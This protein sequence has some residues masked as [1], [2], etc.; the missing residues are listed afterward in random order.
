MQ[1]NIGRRGV[2]KLRYGMIHSTFGDSEGVSIVMKQIGEALHEFGR[3]PVKNISYLVGDSG[4]RSKRVFVE[5]SFSFKS[6]LIAMVKKKYSSGFTNKDVSDLE[7]AIAFG[8][9]R[10]RAYV[11]KNKIDV[12][13]SHNSAY[14][15][16]FVMAL[17]LSRYFSEEKARGKKAPYH[18]VWWHDSHLEREVFLKPSKIMKNYLIEGICGPNVDYIFFINGGQY[19]TALK[20]FRE[21]DRK[22]SGFL[23]KVEKNHLIVYNTSELFI[24]RFSDLEKGGVGKRC[25]EFICDFNVVGSLKSRG[26]NFSET[27]FCLQGTRMV[28]RK[29][30]DFAL[31]YLYKLLQESRSR[32]MYDSIYFLIS[33]HDVDGCRKKLEKLNRELAKKYK[34]DKFVLV[35]AEDYYNKTKL[36]FSDYPQIFARL[37]GVGT[38][39]SELEGFGNN[40]LE[41]VASGLPCLVYEYPVFK[42]DIKNFGFDL[43]SLNKFV[44]TKESIDSIA[45]ILKDRKL[46]ERM[47]NNN[48]RVLKKN[49][50]NE[51]IFGKIKRALRAR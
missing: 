36:D 13:I 34:E 28:D 7:K 46:R 1:F 10:I 50:S 44:V 9:K 26:L 49:F 31:R 33:G 37:G 32:G 19:K 43:I 24:R 15:V 3:V 51:V 16:N 11:K 12:L 41:Y 30:I 23:S 20:Y 4:I 14:P 21:V 42:S 17:S 25:L 29:R 35:F 48:L 27:L 5:K 47:V 6:D 22:Y 38:Y 18:I 39:F 40:L 2:K 8:V 45:W